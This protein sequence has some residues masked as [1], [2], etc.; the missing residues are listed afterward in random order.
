MA[1]LQ[2]SQAPGFHLFCLRCGFRPIYSN[3]WAHS[4]PNFATLMTTHPVVFARVLRHTLTQM[5]IVDRLSRASIAHK[6]IEQVQR[7]VEGREEA[8]G[9][10]VAVE[11][12]ANKVRVLSLRLESAPA[13][14][15]ETAAH[16][17]DGPFVCTYD[18]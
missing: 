7:A 11:Q 6:N 13:D 5:E 17:G 1:V 18:E 3:R 4:H 15:A 16:R 9:G 12:R 10:R 2:S 14:T 8:R